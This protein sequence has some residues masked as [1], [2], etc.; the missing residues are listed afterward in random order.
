MSI[1]VK[2]KFQGHKPVGLF[3]TYKDYAEQFNHKRDKY[4]N[5]ADHRNYEK[6]LKEVRSKYYGS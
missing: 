2:H 4:G 6:W 3:K 1:K 5:I